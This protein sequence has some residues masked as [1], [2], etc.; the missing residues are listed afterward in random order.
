MDAQRH[1]SGEAERL[2]PKQS[3]SF[4][5]HMNLSPRDKMR[6][7]VPYIWLA[8][9]VFFYIDPV[10]GHA[11]WMEWSVTIVS[12]LLF[13]A[14]YL[15]L[16][17]LDRTRP[18]WHIAG[19]VILGLVVA[20][21]NQGAATFF[22][23]AA[24]FIPFCVPTERAAIGLM[25]GIVALAAI[26]KQI[27]HLSG[28]FLFYAGGMSLAVGGSNIYF[29]QRNRALAE[30]RMANDEIEHL[31]KVAE[32]ERIARDLHDVLGHT[33][34]VITL[35]SELAGKLIDRDPARAAKEIREVEEISRQALSEVRAAIRGYRSQGLAAEIV[36]A[37]ATLETAGVTVKCETASVQLPAL[38]ESVLSMAVREAVTNVVRHAQAHTCY[39]RLAQRNGSCRLE[40]EDDGRGG[41]QNEGNG[42]R[43]M[44][45]RVEILGGTLHRD[46]QSGTKLTITLPLKEGVP[47][48]EDCD[49]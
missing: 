21:I 5:R 29:A 3:T 47:K 45:E 20:P 44:R 28:W 9:L 38:Q 43:G 7:W 25:A 36:Q 46:C 32:R 35:K 24:A 15:S 19:M 6:G 34:S 16:F 14:L 26:E 18:L 33:L 4:E 2:S 39:L 13:L 41:S 17:W 1:I 8:Y 23:F 37:K 12:T 22:I 30:L 49:N 10:L 48:T 31:A 11:G 42:L 27:F 40:I